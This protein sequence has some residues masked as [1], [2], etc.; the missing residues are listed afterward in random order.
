MTLHPCHGLQAPHHAAFERI[1]LGMSPFQGDPTAFQCR[2]IGTLLRRGLIDPTANGDYYV[3][4]PV[5]KQ[6]CEWCDEQED[7]K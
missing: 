5:M 4:L 7:M 6:W 3:P 1:A 2:I